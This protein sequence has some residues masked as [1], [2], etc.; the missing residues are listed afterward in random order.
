MKAEQL[1]GAPV[2]EVAAQISMSAPVSVR[3]TA[4]EQKNAR[5]GRLIINADD[6]GRSRETTDLTLDCIKRQT[7]SSVSAMVFME[8][9]ERA[10]AIARASEID[11]ALH[12]NFSAPLTASNLPAGLIERHNKIASYLLLHPLARVMFHP[13]L[14]QSFEYSVRTQVEEF[15]RIYGSEPRRIDG[16]HHLHLCAN[17]L[18]S[19]LLPEGTVAR[20][21]FFFRSDEKNLANRFYRHVIDG[22]LGRRH[23]LVD[24]LFALVP[25]EPVARL[26]NI[27]ALAQHSIV[28]VETHPINSTEHEFLISGEF[29]ARAGRLPAAKFDFPTP[30]TSYK[31]D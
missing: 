21:N 4:L 17:V 28:E 19:A 1:F 30:L 29:F 31:E 14:A 6:W 15:A 22:W 18:F 27:F 3:E 16:H 12:L 20:R 23:R 2:T 9:S 8:D 11:A 13:G 10:A 7:V 26:K 24:F 25:L 5:Q